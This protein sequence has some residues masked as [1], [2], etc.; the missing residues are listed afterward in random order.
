MIYVHN[1]NLY[2]IRCDILKC[3]VILRQLEKVQKFV[4]K[5]TKFRVTNYGNNDIFCAF[6]PI[7]LHCYHYIITITKMCVHVQPTRY[8]K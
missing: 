7:N 2:V 3:F 1:G 4:K 5:I 6:Y 8:L